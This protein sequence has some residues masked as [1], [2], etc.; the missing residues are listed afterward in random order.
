MRLINR[1]TWQLLPSPEVVDAM[2]PFLKDKFGN[3]S[4]MHSL[5][6]EVSDAMNDAREKVA[7]LINA[8]PQRLFLLQEG[9][10]PITGL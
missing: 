4:S 2:L 6:E 3:P 1:T 8:N 10:K 7:G 9:L 5:G